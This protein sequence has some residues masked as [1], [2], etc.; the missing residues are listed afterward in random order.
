MTRRYFVPDLPILGGL[1]SLPE[2]EAQHASR[3]MRV[4]VGDGLVLFDGRGNEAIAQ[5]VEVGRKGCH[6]QAE[7]TQAIDREPQ[8]EIHFAIALPKPDRSR[9]LIERLTEMG[10]RSLT[11]LIAQRTQRPPTDS[12]LAKL[13][14]GV[15]EAC[16]QSGRN[17]L[18]DLR[19]PMRADAFFSACGPGN[20]WIAHPAM[21]HLSRDIAPSGTFH[22]AIGPEGGWTDD[23]VKVAV[24]HSFKPVDLGTRIYR[25][26][27]AATTLAAILAT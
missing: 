2:A 16:K 12:L 3:V 1:V 19:T 10:V 24:S 11:P 18:M 26:E 9:E 17:Q 23:E 22:V 4:Q 5:F 7:A 15:I 25:I 13:Q 14:R 8:R 20:K 6:C 21:D 27:T